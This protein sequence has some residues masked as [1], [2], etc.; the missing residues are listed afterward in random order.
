MLFDT[1]ILVANP[2]LQLDVFLF[3]NSRWSYGSPKVITLTF[4]AR[5]AGDAL[6]ELDAKQ[7][8]KS[9]F[10]LVSGELFSENLHD[11]LVTRIRRKLY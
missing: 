1:P 8:I 6:R 11:T 3:R 2:A 7:V 10:I 5:S 4:D 9:D